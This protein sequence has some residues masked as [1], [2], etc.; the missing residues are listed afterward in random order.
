MSENE[1]GRMEIDD[2]SIYYERA[3]EGE[4]VV[5]LL[6]G[7]LG[8]SLPSLSLLSLLLQLTYC[9]YY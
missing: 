6:P 8:E 7:V 5:L 2:L 9:K 4:H 1:S 3:G